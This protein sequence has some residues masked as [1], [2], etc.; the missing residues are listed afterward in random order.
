MQEK[1]PLILKVPTSQFK[2]RVGR[3]IELAEFVGIAQE[4]CKGHHFGSVVV[5][6]YSNM[7]YFHRALP[8]QPNSFMMFASPEILPLGCNLHFFNLEILLQKIRDN[9]PGISF[10]LLRICQN[11]STVWVEKIPILQTA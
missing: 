1:S 4:S 5:W 10:Q 2:V 6:I 3:G 11:P 9:F 8:G 7:I